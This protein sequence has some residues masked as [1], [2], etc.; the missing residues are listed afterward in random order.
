MSIR[1]PHLTII[2]KTGLCDSLKWGLSVPKKKMTKATSR[3]KIKR[4]MRAVIDHYILEHPL[5]SDKPLAFFIIY[6]H[7]V[8]IPFDD[9]KTFLNRLLGRV[10]YSNE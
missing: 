6:N 8:L 7:D 10:F 5:L 3:N 1:E 9:L 2:Y 4:Q